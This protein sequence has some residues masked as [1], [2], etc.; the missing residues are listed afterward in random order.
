MSLFIGNASINYVEEDFSMKSPEFSYLKAQTMADVFSALKTHGEA[1]QL[2][3]GGQSLLAMLNLRM[4][5]PS[6]LIDISGLDSLKGI[7]QS[8]NVIRIGALTTHHEIDSSHIVKAHIPL[9]AQAVPYVA[10]LAIRNKGTIGGSL[11]LGD[12][13][14]EY[15]AVAL[16]LNATLI[17]QSAAGERRVKA[18]EFFISLYRT[19]V[20]A[21]E[22]LIGVEFPI[23][24]P[25]Q[26]FVFSELAR[27]KGDYA[28]AGMALA[29]SFEGQTIQDVAL[30]FMAMDD[31]PILAPRAMK[32]L[33][34][35]SINSQTI[36]QAQEALD[37]DLQPAGDLAAN[38][39]TK[40]HLSRVLLS[41]ALIQAGATHV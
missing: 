33:A 41:R 10:H 2:L 1:A 20:L 39:A 38:A 36:S 32:A 35:Q 11:A 24:K 31:K 12:P 25:N 9:L 34:G 30:A 18:S 14:A 5:N 16:A 17:I 28:M 40:K 8:G 37:E 23:A 21:D 15:P 26:R 13:A 19:A 3:A 7:Q 4:A 27:R 29:L 6:L 22:I